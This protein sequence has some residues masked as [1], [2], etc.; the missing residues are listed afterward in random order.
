MEHKA[1][2]VGTTVTKSFLPFRTTIIAVAQVL[3]EQDVFAMSE[4]QFVSAVMKASGG[5][6]HPQRV[7]E[8]YQALVREAF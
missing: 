3:Q 8:M 7:R 1:V 5:A 4:H 6:T 2:A